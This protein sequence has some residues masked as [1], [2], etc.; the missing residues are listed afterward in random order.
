MDQ[1]AIKRA[2]IGQHFLLHDDSAPVL[3]DEFDG[4][5]DGDNF[6]TALA[7]D[8]VHHVIERRGFARAGWP[9]NKDETVGPASQVI[10]FFRQAQL[11]ARGDA[12]ATKAKTHLRFAVP[13]IESR[14]DATGEFMQQ[15]NA[16]L[17]FLLEF[18]LLLF[19]QEAVRD[20][21]QVLLRQRILIGN[22]DFAIDAKGRRHA[23]Y[24]VKIGCIKIPR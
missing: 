8:Q 23:G 3:V 4:V 22:N 12:L 6:A 16:Q 21:C 15:R 2:D 9:G 17:P 13:A 11:F 24:Q 10:N 5:F 1:G 20:R 14:S 7:V 18:F 19:I